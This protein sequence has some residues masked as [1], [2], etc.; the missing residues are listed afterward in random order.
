MQEEERSAKG[1]KKHNGRTSA[2]DKVM[3]CILSSIEE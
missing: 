1:K 2:S 3:V